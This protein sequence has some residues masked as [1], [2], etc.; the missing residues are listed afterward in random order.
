MDGSPPGSSVHGISQA[1]ILEGVAISSSGGIFLIQ[2]L[3][4]GLLPLLHCRQILYHLSHQGS[5][6]CVYKYY[7]S[8]DLDLYRR[9]V[10]TEDKLGFPK[11]T[12]LKSD[13][14]F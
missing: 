14:V 6:Y 9:K 10:K 3:N 1:R 2:G 13:N 12:A 4:R 8:H 11:F 7:N 5:Q